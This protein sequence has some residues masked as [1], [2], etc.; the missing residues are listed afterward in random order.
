MLYAEELQGGESVKV[1]Y[2]PSHP[3][4]EGRVILQNSGGLIGLD[5][6]ELGAEE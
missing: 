5:T 6:R 2:G 1:W 4:S 3:Y